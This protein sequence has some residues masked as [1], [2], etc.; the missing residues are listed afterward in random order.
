MN[1]GVLSAFLDVYLDYEITMPSGKSLKVII[2]ILVLPI[3]MVAS[4]LFV[5][6]IIPYAAIKS[7]LKRAWQGKEFDEEKY[8]SFFMNTE[9]LPIFKTFEFC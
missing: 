8:I 5:Y 6:I 3:D 1:N 2:G 9:D 7:G 4:I